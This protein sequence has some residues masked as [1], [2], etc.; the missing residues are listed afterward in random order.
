[1]KVSIINKKHRKLQGNFRWFVVL[2]V[3]SLF[4]AFVAFCGFT[5]KKRIT[6]SHKAYHSLVSRIDSFFIPVKIGKDNTFIFSRDSNA[7]YVYSEETDSIYA[8]DLSERKIIDAIGIKNSKLGSKFNYFFHGNKFYVL[9]KYARAINE[10]LSQSLMHER[11]FHF[12][13]SSSPQVS[14]LPIDLSFQISTDSSIILYRVPKYNI[15]NKEERIKYFSSKMLVKV[16]LE[17][18]NANVVAEFGTFPD[19]YRSAL[20]NEYYPKA[21]LMGGKSVGYMFS[22]SPYLYIFDKNIC[23]KTFLNGLDAN[24]F[25]PVNSDSSALRSYITNYSLMS[26]RYVSALYDKQKKYLYVFQTRQAHKVNDKYLT[27][28]EDKPLSLYVVDS[29]YNVIAK[30]DFEHIGNYFFSSFFCYNGKLYMGK[31]QNGKLLLEV[32]ETK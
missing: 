26:E 5:T 20:Y 10:Y 13:D 24:T 8:Y 2:F 4:T 31:Y 27:L 21:V 25:I 19:A 6:A 14:Y 16:Q 9:K 17:G 22:D 23:K 32:Y 18:Q 15:T 3:V 29:T 1:M 7:Y 30:K 28:W 11:D 12:N